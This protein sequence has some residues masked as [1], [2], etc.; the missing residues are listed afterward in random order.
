MSLLLC[1]EAAK[2]VRQRGAQRPVCDNGRGLGP[3]VVYYIMYI[4]SFYFDTVRNV[5]QHRC[6]T[7]PLCLSFSGNRLPAV[8]FN[9]GVVYRSLGKT[10]QTRHSAHE[11][12]EQ[13]LAFVY[14]SR[15]I[16]YRHRMC[17]NGSYLVLLKIS[18]C[19]NELNRVLASCGSEFDD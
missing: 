1:F 16:P 5:L 15:R 8:W 7:M 4:I 12:S 2:G 9:L 18:G 14:D 6:Y 19:G 10:H 11:D 13:F 17:L 3:E